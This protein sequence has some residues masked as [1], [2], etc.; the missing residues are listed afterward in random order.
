MNLL[1]LENIYLRHCEK[2]LYKKSSRTRIDEAC[3]AAVSY[4]SYHHTWLYIDMGVVQL[5]IESNSEIYILISLY[6]VFFVPSGGWSPH[7]SDL[8][9]DTVEISIALQQPNQY[10]AG[11]AFNIA[12]YE[13]VTYKV[14]LAE[15]GD[16]EV[17]LD[18]KVHCLISFYHHL[19]SM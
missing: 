7:P 5:Y 9:D 12:N 18:R 14:V 3:V 17:P 10:I 8:S 15:Y 13:Q 19:C 1:A 16:V 4:G 11:I 6:L 2:W